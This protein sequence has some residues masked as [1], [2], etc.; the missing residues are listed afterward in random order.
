ME[1][2]DTDLTIGSTF[3]F[4]WVGL[5]VGQ[6]YV[7]RVLGE[8]SFS[9]VYEGRHKDTGDLVAFKVAKPDA[10][11]GKINSMS[12]LVFPTRALMAITGAFGDAPVDTASL[13]QQQYKTLN[14]V[15]HANL[16]RTA[17]L[18]DN[19]VSTYYKCEFVAGENLRGIINSG[20]AGIPH[21]RAIANAMASLTATK[22]F[23]HC[24][25]KPENILFGSN[26]LK[27][28]DPGFIG[29]LTA[30][31]PR[32]YVTTPGYYP[33]LT[34]NDLFAFGVICWEVLV[35]QHPLDCTFSSDM[36][37]DEIKVAPHM[38]EQV[39]QLE[40]GYNYFV[41]PLLN[42]KRPSVLNPNVPVEMDEFLSKTLGV[43]FDE[44]G[45]L[46]IATP[47]SGFAEL[48]QALASFN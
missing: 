7:E 19:G 6:H 39:R 41:S 4:N 10:M 29:N 25:L 1:N 13:L 45:C 9:W 34:A 48:A 44:N 27:L 36:L 47:F 38:V 20:S 32:I 30:D 8:G 42:L 18:T 14:A 12:T 23:V 40:M 3:Q 17:A 15:P 33:F 46:A 21:L 35:G 24:D 5:E 28:I 11:V 26:G 31:A 22:Q 37:T 2:I 43:K 16:L